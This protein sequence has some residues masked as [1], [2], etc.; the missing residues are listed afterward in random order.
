MEQDERELPTIREIEFRIW[1]IGKSS[2]PSTD[3]QLEACQ[4]LIG[5]IRARETDQRHDK[6]E[7]PEE[8]RKIESQIWEIA[9]PGSFG[10]TQL[11]A[12]QCL[13]GRIEAR[14]QEGRGVSIESFGRRFGRS[15]R[16]SGRLPSLAC[17]ALRT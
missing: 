8:I 3:T 15:N 4:C 5:R 9:N 2:A 1:R 13:I 16:K 11:R 6:R 14:E 10:T 17:L 7:L 12:C